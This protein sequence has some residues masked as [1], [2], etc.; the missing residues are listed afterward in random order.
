MSVPQARL[1]RIEQVTEPQVAWPGAE[2]RSAQKRLLEVQVFLVSGHSL[3]QRL[4][5]EVPL[6]SSTQKHSASSTLQGAP[7][8]IAT[9]PCF[10]DAPRHRTQCMQRHSES[11]VLR[12]HLSKPYVKNVTRSA[13]K[14]VMQSSLNT[15]IPACSMKGRCKH[16]PVSSAWRIRS[17]IDGLHVPARCQHRFKRT[18]PALHQRRTTPLHMPHVPHV[19]GPDNATAKAQASEQS[20]AQHE[21]W[22]EVVA[23]DGNGSQT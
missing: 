12:L 1:H 10:L 3:R 6:P 13:S 21:W 4:H 22:R 5:V 23:F 17:H 11:A 18:R 8:F 16:V 19:Q 14:L 7:T 2:S 9:W 15:C 20:G